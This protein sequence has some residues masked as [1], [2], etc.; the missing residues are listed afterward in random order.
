MKY[1][2]KIKWDKIRY[3]YFDMNR[4]WDKVT[5]M[6]W[7]KIECMEFDCYILDFYFQNEAEI[8]Q[9]KQYFPTL[10]QN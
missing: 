4:Y 10:T 5:Y 3:I 6:C 8:D 2:G 1:D 7:D 9:I